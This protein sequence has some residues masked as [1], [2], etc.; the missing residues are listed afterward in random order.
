M[1]SDPSALRVEHPRGARR[2]DAVRRIH[3]V[4]RQELRDVADTNGLLPDERLLALRF[5]A[6]RNAIRDALNL[7]RDEG[8]VERRQG[9]GTRVIAAGPL[10]GGGGNGLVKGIPNG[11]D[12]VRYESLWHYE[13]AA[14]AS[15]A[16]RLRVPAGESVLVLERLTSVD[17]VPT[18]LWTTY[19]RRSEGAAVVAVERQCDS[20]ELIEAA[21]HVH[22]AQVDMRI[23]AV[24]ADESVAHHLDVR[25]GQ[26]LLRFERLILDPSGQVIALGFGRAPGDR[27]AILTSHFRPLAAPQ[28]RRAAEARKDNES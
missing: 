18:C 12:R 24:L 11:P 8:I 13:V 15:I 23:E 20:F 19:M 2:A 28:E 14:S 9:S 3:D 22:V 26:P 27:M 7:L 6:S 25:V 21:L 5:G 17:G 16:D 4:L 10:A 1:S